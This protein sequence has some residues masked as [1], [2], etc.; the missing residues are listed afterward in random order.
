MRDPAVEPR[1]RRAEESPPEREPLPLELE[2]DRDRHERESRAGDEREARAVLPGRDPERQ[3]PHDEAGHRERHRRGEKADHGPVPALLERGAQDREEARAREDRGEVRRALAARAPPEDERV[4]DEEHP[5]NAREE[6]DLVP[7]RAVR[8]PEA[9]REGREDRR[10]RGEDG[11]AR[12]G[13]AGG[14][15]EERD[16][17]EGVRRERRP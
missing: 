16:E 9:P 8:T 17:E 13:R 1:E 3:E 6:G 5:E 14:D 7:G 15:R 12:L 10:P 2:R 11:E 4:E